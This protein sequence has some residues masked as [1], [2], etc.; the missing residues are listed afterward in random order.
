MP[1]QEA[2]NSS[3]PGES[4]FLE[5]KFQ[6]FMIH[7]HHVCQPKL[8]YKLFEDVLLALAPAHEG[9]E[10]AEDGDRE[11][12]L[13]YCYFCHDRPDEHG[14]QLAQTSLWVLGFTS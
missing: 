13:V 10:D 12:G 6:D 8:V 14:M 2:T 4:R 7:D 5:I 9:E 11:H 3:S 1:E